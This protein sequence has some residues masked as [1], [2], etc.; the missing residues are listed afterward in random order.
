MGGVSGL[1]FAGVLFWELVA[2]DLDLLDKLSTMDWSR[3]KEFDGFL[4]KEVSLP[5]WLTLIDVS[6]SCMMARA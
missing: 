6:D 5:C 1:K 4:G 3:K 2:V